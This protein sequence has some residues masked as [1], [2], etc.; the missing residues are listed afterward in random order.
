MVRSIAV[1][2]VVFKDIFKVLWK[3]L[4]V[5]ISIG[6]GLAI[7]NFISLIFFSHYPLDI[8]LIVSVTLIATITVAKLIGSSLPILAKK[9]GLDPAI[10]AN[11]MIS[12]ILDA[13]VL[14]TYF[15]ICSMALGI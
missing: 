5:S 6:I 4:R 12:T 2:D 15:S 11:P 1:G 9:I 10:M 13:L 7:L 8:S 3:E 14:I